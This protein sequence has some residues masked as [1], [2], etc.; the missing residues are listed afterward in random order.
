MSWYAL[1]HSIR[2]SRKYGWP[3]IALFY[4]GHWI[5]VPR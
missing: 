3:P 1:W 2:Y 4:G 5:V